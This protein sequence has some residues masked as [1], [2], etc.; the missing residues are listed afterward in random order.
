MIVGTTIIHDGTGTTPY[1]TPSFPRGGPAAVFSLEVTHFAGGTLI[2]GAAIEHKNEAD[3]SWGTAAS[4]TNITAE[5]LSTKDVSG[6]KEEIRLAF[7]FSDG[8][9]GNFAHIVIAAPAWR[10]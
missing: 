10:P 2:L 9:V 1:Y 8:A 6:L 4:F 5:G 3:T 7:T